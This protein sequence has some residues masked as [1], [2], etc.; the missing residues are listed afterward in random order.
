MFYYRELVFDTEEQMINSNLKQKTMEFI[1][2][3]V[4]EIIWKNKWRGVG[5]LN[6]DCVFLTWLFL[7][8]G[9]TGQQGDISQ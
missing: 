5:K 7:G 3:D 1:S 2:E 8:V 6:K 4:V 9:R